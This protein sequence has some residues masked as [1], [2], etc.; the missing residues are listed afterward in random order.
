MLLV[1]F[2]REGRVQLA[3]NGKTIMAYKGNIILCNGMQV[4]SHAMFSIDF[5][6]DIICISNRRIDE[7]IHTDNKAME[8]FL[9][10]N[11]NPVLELSEEESGVYD[12]YKDILE[13]KLHMQRHDYFNRSFDGILTAAIYDFLAIIQRQCSANEPHLSVEA[14]SDHAK[15]TVRKFLLMLVEDG[16]KHHSVQYFADQLCI[17]PKYLAAICKQQ[18]GK[19]PS[20]WI[21]EQMIEKIRSMLVNTTL[22]SKEIAQS[23]EF[24][25]PSFFG[26]FVRQH[27]GCTPIEFRK[28]HK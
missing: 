12:M 17:T 21:R 25:N 22:S 18:T 3:V 10:I 19:T 1:A 7:I 4:L 23:L 6:C 5:V 14:G 9:Y 16:S 27:L 13:R 11:D 2:C 8:N 28:R 15:A 24:P 26:R 20:L